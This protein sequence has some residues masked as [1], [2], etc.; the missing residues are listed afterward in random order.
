MKKILLLALLV[1][2]TSVFSQSNTELLKHFEAYYKEM[3]LR[4]DV[5]GAINGLSHLDILQPSQAKKDTLAYLYLS[6]GRNVQALNTIGIEKNASDSD[7][8]VEVKALALKAVGQPKRA[9]E[10]FEVMFS[11]N[12][13]ALI[14]YELADL[15]TQISDLVGA[16]PH[17]E[18]GIA[19]A[20][21]DQKRSFYEMQT[22]Y[23]VP[24]KAAFL[25]LKALVTFN[26]D[27]ANNVDAAVALLEQALQI[28]P[29]FNMASISKDALIAKKPKE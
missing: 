27:Q 7:I 17:I 1:G 21:D 29:N 19:N 28:E 24:V 13:N 16:K 11:R 5:Q 9:V 6:E 22:P 3:K 14:A 23:Q 20:K 18:Y 10:H 4:G 25:Y 2:S 12:P 8:A 26:E 15:K